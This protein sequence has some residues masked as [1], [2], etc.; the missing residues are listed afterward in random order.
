MKNIVTIVI[1]I[2]LGVI[3]FVSG[4]TID[5]R[6]NREQELA[7]NLPSC[8]EESVNTLLAEKQYDINN[9][10]EFLADL[11]GNLYVL[12]DSENDITVEVEDADVE[13]GILAIRVT[14]EYTHPN[15][16]V[17]KVSTERTVVFDKRQNEEVN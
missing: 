17:G 14:A 6:S 9:R 15:G 8:V 2:M 4:L 3:F 5:G 12:L 1:V 10:N 16:K 7:E 11:I 13:K